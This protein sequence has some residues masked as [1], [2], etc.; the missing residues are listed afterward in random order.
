M[1][2]YT[3]LETILKK[4]IEEDPHRFSSLE[5]DALGFFNLAYFFMRLNTC[6]GEIY[7]IICKAH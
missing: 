2:L 5:S 7:L 4:A 1:L 3:N 6:L